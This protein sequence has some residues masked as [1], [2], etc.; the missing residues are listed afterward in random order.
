MAVAY[1]SSSTANTAGG[2]ASFSK[3]SGLAVGDLMVCVVIGANVGSFTPSSG[4]TGIFSQVQ[5]IGSDATTASYYK[6]ATSG[7]VA[8]STFDF[9]YS[10]GAGVVGILMR[11]TGADSTHIQST[12]SGTPAHNPY[13][14]P[15][16]VIVVGCTSDN[17]GTAATFTSYA[18]GGGDSPT[19]T[20]QL[21]DS[22]TFAMDIS[23]GVATGLY[24]SL[25]TITSYSVTNSGSVDDSDTFL[26]TIPGVVN[27]TGTHALLSADADFFDES[28]SAGTTG[29]NAL[30][31][32]DADFFAV[33][34]RGDVM[35]VWR[36]T[37]KPATS[38][39]T[40]IT[41]T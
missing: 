12:T 23:L 30:L 29:T 10:A 11:I 19:M 3:P 27:A 24:A 13:S 8:A 9:V 26:I 7:D 1:A 5:N 22:Q 25:A 39:F 33:D 34:G 28:G 20:E 18:V 35:P 2:T 21:D 37:T 38:T 16:L 15:A 41:K 40:N 17:D 36:N 4:F 32:A 6:V 14:N 31:S